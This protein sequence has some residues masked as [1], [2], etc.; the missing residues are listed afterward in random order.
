MKGRSMT[1]PGPIAGVVQNWDD[2]SA[3]Q[4]DPLVQP[5]YEYD[6]RVTW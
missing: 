3:T 1:E 2:E 6:Q 5:E 4:G